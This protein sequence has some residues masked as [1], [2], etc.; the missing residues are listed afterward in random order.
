MKESLLELLNKKHSHLPLETVVSGCDAWN[1]WTSRQQ[2][3]TSLCT[4]LTS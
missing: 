3:G 1:D 4:K 2:K